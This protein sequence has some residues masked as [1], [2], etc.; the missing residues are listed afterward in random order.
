ML[1]NFVEKISFFMI[2]L[3]S[4]FLFGWTWWRSSKFSFWK[5]EQHLP[6]NTNKWWKLVPS[7]DKTCHVFFRQI[8]LSNALF[9]NISSSPH[10]PW[11]TSHNSGNSC[12]LRQQGK[13]DDYTFVC[14]Y[15]V[16]T[17]KI[18]SQ[19]FIVD[20]SHLFVGIGWTRPR[21]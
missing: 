17:N 21:P 4:R 12:L 2:F 14:Y 15:D 7:G 1:H 19:I 5:L 8:I 16:S 13:L 10:R 9:Q 3:F 11:N 18:D 6:T 20:R